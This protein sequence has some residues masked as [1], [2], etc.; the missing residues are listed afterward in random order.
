MES[1]SDPPFCPYV[2][3]P[4]A[5][6]T[7]SPSMPWPRNTV[8]MQNISVISI[9]PIRLKKINYTEGPTEFPKVHSPSFPLQDIHSS[10]F[11]A[12]HQDSMFPLE[13]SGDEASMPSRLSE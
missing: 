11:G 8:S 13:K 2:F 12:G 1:Q 3:Q 4:S 10:K 5:N 7:V 6:C 9:A